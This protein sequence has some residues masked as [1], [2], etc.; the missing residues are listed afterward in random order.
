[1]DK[2]TSVGQM[3]GMGRLELHDIQALREEAEQVE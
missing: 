2:K 1:M 3:P